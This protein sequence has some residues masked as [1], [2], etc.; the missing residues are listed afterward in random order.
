MKINLT[1][2]VIF[3]FSSTSAQQ[4][5]L[6]TNNNKTSIRGLSVVNDQIA[7]VSGSNGT[8]GKSTDGG[9]TWKWTVVKNF[10]KRDFRD[11]EAFDENTAIIMAIAEP[12]NILKTVDGGNTWKTVFID[13]TKGMFLDAMDFTGKK[14]VVIG[15]PVNQKIFSAYTEDGGDSWKISPGLSNIAMPDGEAFFASSGTNIKVTKKSFTPIFVSG[16]TR[17]SIYNSATFQHILPIEQGRTSTG[18]NSIALSPKNEMEGI[19]VGGD[20]QNDTSTRNNCVLFSLLP[21]SVHSPMTAPHGYRSCVEYISENRLVSCGTSGVD[22]S[23]DGGM[24]WK[25]IS[26]ESFH[27]CAKAKEGNA[28]FLAGINGKIARLIW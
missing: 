22:I 14:G 23:E 16:G 24:N 17:S 5:Q 19:V 26:K 8:V 3:F 9:N 6:L 11:I 1:L 7:W 20:F 27:V 15:D 2:I 18:A 21:Y 13:S 28:V 25:L 10:E 12:A 4:I